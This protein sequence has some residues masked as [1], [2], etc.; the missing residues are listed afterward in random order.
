MYFVISVVENKQNVEKV[1]AFFVKEIPTLHSN[2]ATN[3][4]WKKKYF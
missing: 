3:C 1:K 2:I 4:C